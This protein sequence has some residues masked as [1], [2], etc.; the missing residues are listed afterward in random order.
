MIWGQ[1][2]S[3]RSSKGNLRL[4]NVLHQGSQYFLKWYTFC[5]HIVNLLYSFL[6]KKK[7][8]DKIEQMLWVKAIG[9]VRNA[10]NFI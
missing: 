2:H 3:S 4:N 10:L 6:F 7:I 9:Q 1:G 5:G 8:Y